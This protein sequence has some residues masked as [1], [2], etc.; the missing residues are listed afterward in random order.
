MR[1]GA[2]VAGLVV[3]MAVALAGRAPAQTPEFTPTG[4][5]ITPTAA[6]GA[7]FQP[8]NPHLA[9]DPNYT[10]GQATA[11]ARRAHPADPDQRLQPG[12]RA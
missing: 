1:A 10:A 4:Q 11:V 9:G 5:F 6:P 12:V 7:V 8:L 3:A 2:G